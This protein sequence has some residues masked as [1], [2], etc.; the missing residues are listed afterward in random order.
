MIWATD[1]SRIAIDYRIGFKPP[2]NRQ[3]ATLF[4]F[5]EHPRDDM[6]YIYL[7]ICTFLVW[8]SNSSD[9]SRKYTPL[10]R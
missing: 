2:N 8:L 9:N 5:A 3:I 6:F 10:D 4:G 7:I 1:P